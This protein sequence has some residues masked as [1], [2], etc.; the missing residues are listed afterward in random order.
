MQINL[1][2]SESFDFNI[3][4]GGENSRIS[5]TDDSVNANIFGLGTIEVTDMASESV[6]DVV[7]GAFSSDSIWW[8]YVGDGKINGTVVDFDGNALSKVSV[9]LYRYS[10]YFDPNVSYTTPD[11]SGSTDFTDTDSCPDNCKSRT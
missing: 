7:A 11:Y 9:E 3:L 5:V 2:S 6:N 8:N 10:Q 4:S 1:I